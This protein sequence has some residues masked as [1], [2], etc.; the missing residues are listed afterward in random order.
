L[1]IDVIP[2][3]LFKFYS[4]R[5]WAEK[6]LAG[7]LLCRSVSYYRDMEDEIRGDKNEGCSEYRPQGGL[8]INNITQ[9]T[10]FHISNSALL[11]AVKQDEI[12]A[13][14]MSTSSDAVVAKQLGETFVEILDGPEFVRRVRAALPKN[15]TFFSRE[16][17]YYDASNPP[18]A[19]W[20]VPEFIST[21]KQSSPTYVSQAEY[22]LVFS[23]TDALEFEK[24]ALSITTEQVQLTP[25]RNS[26]PK[27]IINAGDLTDICRMRD[28]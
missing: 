5:R 20:A 15:A 23:L 1:P 22:R 21:A 16:V 7:E 18:E 26:Y 17:E 4:E 10:S 25:R 28:A 11:S 9:G 13:F 2:N 27:Y 12:F 3:S 19:R 24:V 8:L 14:C 6:L